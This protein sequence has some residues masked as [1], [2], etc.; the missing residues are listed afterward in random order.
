M[1]ARL[2][3]VAD[4]SKALSRYADAPALRKL[5]QTQMQAAKAGASVAQAA[6]KKL[7]GPDLALAN[8]ARR[9]I[10]SFTGC[11]LGKSDALRRDLELSDRLVSAR[12]QLLVGGAVALTRLSDPAALAAARDLLKR[13]ADAY[14]ALRVNA[15]R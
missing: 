9:G 3:A 11:L 2:S 13:G 12:G 6:L 15:P 14:T 7:G 10:G 1:V 4:V 5:G 8:R